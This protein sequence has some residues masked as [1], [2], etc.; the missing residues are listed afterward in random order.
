MNHKFILPE[1]FRPNFQ[2]SYANG[3]HPFDVW[4]QHKNL[5]VIEGGE[6]EVWLFA[7]VVNGVIVQAGPY[8]SHEPSNEVT[9]ESI[10][11]RL[12]T[13]FGDSESVKT[14]KPYYETD[15]LLDEL[16]EKSRAY[17][18]KTFWMPDGKNGEHDYDI[19]VAVLGNDGDFTIIMSMAVRPNM[20][21]EFSR[22]KNVDAIQVSV[23]S[24]GLVYWLDNNEY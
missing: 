14:G 23:W 24:K 21:Y 11:N 10:A 9:N 1:D 20:M 13:F 17:M 3:D 22:G 7:I 8:Y 4:I 18:F 6:R 15:P 19:H 5:A 12:A 2:K 16:I